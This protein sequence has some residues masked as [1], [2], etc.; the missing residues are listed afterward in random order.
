MQSLVGVMG[1]GGGSPEE[2]RLAYL[3]GQ[4]VAQSG[5]VLLSGG[6]QGTM[7]EACRGAKRAGG[8]VVAI[9]PL[10][11]R[12]LLNPFVDIPIV[13]GMGPGRNFMNILS[14][15]RV[16]AISGNS[17]G[18]LSEIAHA[19]QLGRPLMVVGASELTRTY[20]E[21]F[22]HPAAPP[23]EF[24]KLGEEVPEFLARPL[25]VPKQKLFGRR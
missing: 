24:S 19:I 14:S 16:I 22:N 15:E 5:K 21:S 11:D 6:M 3:V 2:L 20:L 1:P 13:T 4:M 8:L 25:P 7:E 12:S 18:T 9:C 10:G 23:I 17:P